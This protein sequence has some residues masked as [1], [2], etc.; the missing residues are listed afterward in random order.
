L[1]C[2]GVIGGL[3]FKGPIVA[4]DLRADICRR[5]KC[6]GNRR[7]SRWFSGEENRDGVRSMQQVDGDRRSIASLF[8]NLLGN[9]VVYG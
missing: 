5:A 4:T 7:T 9:S 1:A 2:A 8:S 6:S 3:H